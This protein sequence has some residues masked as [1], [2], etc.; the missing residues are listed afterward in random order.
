MVS[1]HEGF[2][3][4]AASLSSPALVTGLF[5]DAIA[6]RMSKSPVYT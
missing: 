5:G 2:A 3:G 6:Y 1:P 4:P